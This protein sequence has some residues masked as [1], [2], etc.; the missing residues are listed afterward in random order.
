ME[1][2]LSPPLS[3]PLSLPTLPPCVCAHTRVC[4]WVWDGSFLCLLFSFIDLCAVFYAVLVIV[5]YCGLIANLNKKIISPLYF[6]SIV[7]AVSSTCGVHAHV[8]VKYLYMQKGPSNAGETEN[9]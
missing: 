4:V 8:R 6:L 2:I 5:D 3:L 9:S 7:L 1:F